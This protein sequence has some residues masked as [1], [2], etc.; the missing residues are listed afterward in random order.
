[1]TLDVSQ[2][3][4]ESRPSRETAAAYLRA[5]RDYFEDG[6]IEEETLLHAVQDVIT[7]PESTP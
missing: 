2:E 3:A 5:A 7:W 1:M 4:F 6:M